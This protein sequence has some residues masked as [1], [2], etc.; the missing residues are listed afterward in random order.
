[1][2]LSLTVQI[3]LRGLTIQHCAIT[4]CRGAER[5]SPVPKS[6]SIVQN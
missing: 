1:M 4:D 6:I 2:G 5:L 3:R